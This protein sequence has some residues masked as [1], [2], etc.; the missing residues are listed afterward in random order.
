MSIKHKIQHK[1]FCMLPYGIRQRIKQ[2]L[3]NRRNKKANSV[4]AK[5]D[6]LRELIIYNHPITEIPPC[7]GKLRLLQQGNTVLLNYFAK[8]CIKAGLRYWLD[9]GT[10]LGAVRHGGFIPWDDDLDVAMLKPEYDKMK[11]L[12]PTLFSEEKGFTVSEHAFI[13]IGVKGTP[14]NLDIFPYYCHSETSTDDNRRQ[15]NLRLEAIR[16]QIVY[17]Y[18]ILNKTEE[19][20]KQ[21]MNSTIY[22]NKKPLNE[23]ESPLIFFTP[24]PNF[25]KPYLFHYQDIFP[26]KEINFEGIS[27]C[28]PAHTRQYLAF[29]YGDYMTYPP[30]VG[31]WHQHLINVVKRT[32]FEDKV[33]QFIDTYG[34]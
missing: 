10:L 13:Q 16:K 21:L 26:L 7:T 29:I 22:Q 23:E 6:E 4:Q 27:F 32:P 30:K 34:C 25:R 8:C 2:F 28:A 15:L 12:L 11:E 9:F 1:I 3:A 18:G 5:L 33:N 14:L 19:E 31:M 24:I 20:F 17:K